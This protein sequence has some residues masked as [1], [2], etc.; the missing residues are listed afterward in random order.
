MS[1]KGGQDVKKKPVIHAEM[2]SYK[3]GRGL[4]LSLSGTVQ[5]VKAAQKI[6][7]KHL[8]KKKGAKK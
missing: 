1:A 6:L 2:Y 4:I 7:D 3:K 8:F 5:A